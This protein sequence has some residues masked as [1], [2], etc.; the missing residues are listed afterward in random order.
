MKILVIAPRVALDES[1]FKDWTGL[2]LVMKDLSEG[3][4]AAGHR[5]CTVTPHV[6]RLSEGR[7][8]PDWCF[9]RK[10]WL[11]RIPFSE[12]RLLPGVVR[13]HGPKACLRRARADLFCTLDRRGDRRV[14]PRYRAYPFVDPLGACGGPAL[15]RAR[16]PFRRHA[17]WNQC[18]QPCMRRRCNRKRARLPCDGGRIRFGDNGRQRRHGASDGRN[19]ARACGQGGSRRQRVDP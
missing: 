1:S 10:R 13:A 8:V 11:A 12:M 9:Q 14:R 5:V 2:D 6:Y 16:H 19:R 3:Y 15:H 7:C 4:A 17:P 18:D